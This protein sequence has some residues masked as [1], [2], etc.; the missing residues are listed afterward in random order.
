MLDTGEVLIDV[1]IGMDLGTWSSLTVASLSGLRERLDELSSA[2]EGRVTEYE[3]K[4]PAIG[5]VTGFLS[6]MREL[7]ALD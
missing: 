5:D 1:T 6:A 2:F 7:A 3:N 4:V